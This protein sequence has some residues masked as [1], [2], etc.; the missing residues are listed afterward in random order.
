MPDPDQDHA[1]QN[2]LPG[3]QEWSGKHAVKVYSLEPHFYKVKLGFAGV[4]LYF[5]YFCSKT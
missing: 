4:Y 3:N 1:G 2:K 5:S